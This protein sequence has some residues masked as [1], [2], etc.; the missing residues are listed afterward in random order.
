MK[1][2]GRTLLMAGMARCE[3]ADKILKRE[4]ASREEGLSKAIR[5]ELA[6]RHSMERLKEAI[7]KL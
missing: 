6:N 5:A 7:R 3:T 4:V 2:I 1:S